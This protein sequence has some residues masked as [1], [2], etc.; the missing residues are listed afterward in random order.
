MAIDLIRNDIN[1]GWQNWNGGRASFAVAG[2]FGG[3]AVTLQYLA[4]DG[5]TALDVGAEV[6]LGAPGLA[7]FELGAGQIR[8]V[9]SGGSPSGL[10]ARVAK[11]P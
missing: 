2:N 3:A 5:A 1:A 6:T 8:A 11:V 7:N 4:P 9:V 10:Y